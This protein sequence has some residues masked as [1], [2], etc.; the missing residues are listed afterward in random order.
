MIGGNMDEILIPLKD[1]AKDATIPQLK[2]WAKLLGIL[3]IVRG[4][5]AHVYNNDAQK[6]LKIVELVKEGKSPQEAAEMIGTVNR[7]VISAEEMNN[8][9]GILGLKEKIERLEQRN[10]GIEKALLAMV[11]EMRNLRQE[12]SALKKFLMPPP[13]PLKMVIPWQPKTPKDPLEGMTWFQQ[14]YVKIFQPQKLRQ[15]DS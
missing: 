6:L 14:V 7:A 12:N 10:E 13:E 3:L 5:V 15:Y 8:N 2:Y 9:A 1:L 11:D 4:R